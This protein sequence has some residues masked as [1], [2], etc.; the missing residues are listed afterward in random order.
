M[1]RE[2]RTSTVS[3]LLRPD[4]GPRPH[5]I[6]RILLHQPHP[7]APDGHHLSVSFSTPYL[8]PIPNYPDGC[9]VI[10]ESLSDHPAKSKLAISKTLSS[11]IVVL[12]PLPICSI[13]CAVGKAWGDDSIQAWEAR[14]WLD[15]LTNCPDKIDTL[16]AAMDYQF[17]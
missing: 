12:I 3:I 17:L 10:Y 5:R 2:S 14:L 4:R 15:T 9:N 13:S 11:S 7:S 8:E 16:D 6:L 1:V